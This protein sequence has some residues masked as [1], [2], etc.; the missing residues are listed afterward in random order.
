[1]K[2][3]CTTCY[4]SKDSSEFYP[5]PRLRSGLRSSCISCL[6]L[7]ASMRDKEVVRSNG[8]KNSKAYH[9]RLRILVL[10]AYGGENP[11]CVCC[12]ENTLIFLCIDHINNNGS[13]HRQEIG[14]NRQQPK[15]IGSSGIYQWLKNNNFPKGFQVLCFN[16]NMAKSFNGGVC[17]HQG[18]TKN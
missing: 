1:M 3:E 2:K 16:C 6:S 8:R 9:T 18:N 13:Q 4:E 14:K 7:R 12:K 11:C 5:D 15:N 10:K 17:P